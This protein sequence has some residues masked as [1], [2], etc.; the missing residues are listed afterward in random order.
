M[1]QG[2]KMTEVGEIPEDWEVKRIGEVF[3][4][5]PTAS[6]SREQM[7]V[8]GDI[9]CIHY[10]DIHT[11]F[12]AILNT[13]A[14]DLPKVTNQQANHYR[15]LQDGDLVLADA[16]EDYAGVGA[17]TYIY[18]TQNHEVISGLHTIVLR[19]I[20]N[21]FYGYYLAYALKDKLTKKAL[22]QAS[23]GTKV[24][25][26]SFNSIRDCYIKVPSKK[27]Q[28][29][30]GSALSNIDNLILSQQALIEKK[31]L[32]KQ[33][34]MQKLLTG[35]ER[36]PG[37][38]GEWVEKTIGEIA[39]IKKGEFL[40]SNQYVR[41]IYP[42]IAGGK[43][44]AGHHISANRDGNIISISAS[45]AYAGY[46]AFHDQPIFATDCTT[47]MGTS[48]YETKFIYYSLI[49]KQEYIYEL[50]TGGAQPHIYPKDISQTTIFLPPTLQEQR[51]IASALTSLDNELIALEAELEKYRLMKQGMMQELL[52]GKTRLI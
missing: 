50:Q 41:G 48:E 8:I 37:C 11:K 12:N 49:N 31:K 14:C 24:Y 34:A 27:E 33:G 22:E 52:T 23:V 43:S 46:V 17:S 32:M 5:F 15:R 25:S 21:I 40:N 19:P 13:S 30:I 1:R 26:I 2:Y 3:T 35:E 44:P 20:E 36:M 16:S 38:E 42:V 45:G 10:G 4:T 39:E 18:N 6:F 28:I 7:S 9:S 29:L 47:I 51:L